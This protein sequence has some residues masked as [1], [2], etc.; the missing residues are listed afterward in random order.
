[1]TVGAVDRPSV[2]RMTPRTYAEKCGV[3]KDTVY[4]WVKKRQLP[5]G[6]KAMKPTGS[7][8][9][10]I[11]VDMAVHPAMPLLTEER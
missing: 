6:A 11:E 7:N 9:L 10:V 4:A 2:R 1:M 5:N 3:G 8:R